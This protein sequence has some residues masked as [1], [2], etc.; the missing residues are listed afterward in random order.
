MSE[1]QPTSNPVPNEYTKCRLKPRETAAS[2]L[3]HSY[4][5]ILSDLQRIDPSLET[6]SAQVLTCL[7][8][9][10]CNVELKPVLS[11]VR[12]RIAGSFGY[13]YLDQIENLS[14]S[15]GEAYTGSTEN[16]LT[17][18][19]DMTSDITAWELLLLVVIERETPE[20]IGKNS[21]IVHFE[22]GFC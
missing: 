10:H 19:R 7:I 20:S 14:N 4:W 9:N 18:K 16:D 15:L 11:A 6:G 12:D 22:K 1:E 8:M 2:N 13:S 3:A 5:K 21:S 17:F